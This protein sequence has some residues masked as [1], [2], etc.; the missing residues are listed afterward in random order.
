MYR[1]EA[2][3]LIGSAAMRR[4]LMGLACVAG[5]AAAD[6]S[7]LS[8]GL[9]AYAVKATHGESLPLAATY[10]SGA[11]AGRAAPTNQWYSSVVFERWS[12]PLHAHPMTYRAAEAGFEIG[13]PDRSVATSE[14]EHHQVRYAH[15]AAI[16]VSPTAFKPAD[17]R[18]SASSDWLAEISMAGGEGKALTATVLHG[19]PFSYY[20]CSDGD[21][22]LHLAGV[23]A[24]FA[25]PGEAG[26]DARV[27]AFTLAGHAYAVFAPT[28]ASWDFTSPSEPLLHLPAD[29]RY[30]SIAGLPNA[31]AA[32]LRDFLALAY[33]F[34]TATRADWAYD[35]KSSIV[36][37]S[38]TVETVAREG[39]NLAT[40]MGLYPHQWAAAAP[41]AKSQYQF[42]SVRGPIRL[43]K[44][45]GFT[46]E[47][48]F[49]GLMPYWAGLESAEHKAAVDSLLVGDRAKAKQLFT[50]Q[51][52][53]GSYW[54][55]KGIGGTAQLMSVA[56]AEGNTAMRD[57]LLTALEE[58][59]QN[60]FDGRHATHFLQDTSL[61]TFAAYPQEFGSV[62]HM[63]DHHF[64]Y[65]YWLLGAAHI[66]LRDPAWAAADH[67]GG[68]VNKL[69]ADIATAERGRTDFPFLR[70]FDSYE[71]HSWAS[72]DAAF[73]DGNNQES[74]S[75]AVNAWAGLALWGEATGN[76]RL[77]DLGIYLYTAE[78]ASI[79]A[80]WFDTDHTVFA[81]GY[82]KPFAS[83]IF[84]GSYDYN[85]WWTQEP[86][87][88]TGI[89]LLPITP[90]STYLGLSPGTVRGV[91]DDLP[92]QVAAYSARGLSDGTPPDIWQDLLCSWLA[93]AD[94]DAALAAWNKH[95]SVESGET[96]SHTL[97]WLL[98]LKE[99][100]TPDL[101]VTANTALYAVFKN[102]SGARTYLAYNAG[103]AAVQVKFSTG[104]TVDIPPRSLARSH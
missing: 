77:R 76:K 89:N 95:G 86:R 97:F 63:N 62:S 67:W 43:V 1:P 102:A 20:Q 65:G 103:S 9:G 32:T 46:V 10:R 85:T 19:S 69:V 61:G 79:Q 47:R 55:G 13:L 50:K 58:R 30:F 17:A 41:A 70:N 22:R 16:T 25:K 101:G 81:P 14:R 100:G 4:L 45:N 104:K 18:L 59:F 71:G 80:Y 35:E 38:F 39:S 24:V 49:H 11:A 96:R 52:G 82:S 8:A 21:V 37:T 28:G 34:P 87:Q 54:I 68:M 99:M 74:S 98:S 7:T 42:D 92:K 94:P 53:S 44:G 83:M 26:N 78:I 40:F 33:A 91:I 5:L 12:S 84:G 56:E 6:D 29:R 15:V 2:K 66:A 3:G 60:W 75:E 93:L 90:A 51:Q 88:I 23:P 72:G 48:A 57:D 31:Q 27:L 36:R 73:D 64:H